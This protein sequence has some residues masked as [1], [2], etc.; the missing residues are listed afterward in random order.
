MSTPSPLPENF[1]RR[2]FN[3]LTEKQVVL[4]LDALFQLL[5]ESQ[6]TTLQQNLDSDSARLLNNILSSNDK[7]KENKKPSTPNK[8]EPAS[9]AK[10]V[11]N[12]SM[13]WE[14][15]DVI[16]DEVGEEEGDYAESDEDWEPPYFDV[17]RLADDLN[18]VAEYLL[19][20]LEIIH[21]TDIAEDDLFREA[22]HNIESSIQAYPEWIYVDDAELALGEFITG[23]LL[24]WEWLNAQHNTNNEQKAIPLFLETIAFFTKDMKYIGWDNKHF[25]NQFLTFPEPIQEAIYHYLHDHKDDK[26]W[27]ESLGDAY[28][29]WSNLYQMYAKLFNKTDYLQRCEILLTQ[30]WHLGKA[31]I[32]QAIDEK[33]YEKASHLLDKT[34][35][36]YVNENSHRKRKTWYPQKSLLIDITEYNHD[37]T[38]IDQLLASW[39]TIAQTTQQAK[40][41]AALA[42]QRVTYQQ[43][44]EWTKVM[45]VYQ[46]Q[47]D[48]LKASIKPLTTQWK[49]CTLRHHSVLKEN[50]AL[51][52][53]WIHWL[54]SAELETNKDHAWFEDKMVTWL[55][56]VGKNATQFKQE[57]PLLARLTK[58]INAYHTEPLSALSPILSS[59]QYDF[60]AAE[61]AKSRQSLLQKQQAEQHLAIISHLWKTYVHLLTPN[62]KDAYKADYT[63]HVEWLFA[64]KQINPAS[65]QTILTQWKKEHQRR[66][67]LW[68]KFDTKMGLVDDE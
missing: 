22:L 35:N 41:N 40:L 52:N 51:S 7:A 25:V 17:C 21:N 29:M 48:S 30:N 14:K 59:I 13:L 3:G 55:S 37:I 23:C 18:D 49:N 66:R 31:L 68:K 54:L 60:D 10:H 50:T 44:D 56:H 53:N 2:L 11:A 9:Y 32:D 24:Q 64:L 8:L 27:S 19:P 4:L 62:P 5:N 65:Y 45:D 1:S 36:A 61:L 58:D 33:A 16:V 39:Q 67:N 34:M 28:S 12:W 26:M 15:W 57:A 20:M 6:W 43:C 47:T 38:E 63:N 46:A 42:F